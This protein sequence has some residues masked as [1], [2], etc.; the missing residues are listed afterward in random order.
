MKL[1]SAL[2][3]LHLLFSAPCASG[4]ARIAQA[5]IYSITP[6]DAEFL[7]ALK[8]AILRDN[9]AW[10][11]ERISYPLRVNG[12]GGAREI[13]DA[14]ELLENFERVFTGKVRSAILAQDA[15][16]LFRNWSGMMIGNGEVWFEAVALDGKE[17]K[18]HFILAI[19]N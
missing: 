1:L 14:S 10:V 19:N 16:R 12:E 4:S 6:R 8:D 15:A 9:R 11:A 3:G 18:D 7:D 13:R 17:F 2:L 5:S